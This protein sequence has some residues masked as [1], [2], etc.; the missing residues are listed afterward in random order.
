[1]Y[2]PRKLLISLAATC[3]M[4]GGLAAKTTTDKPSRGDSHFM[5]RAAQGDQAEIQMGRL[6][7]QHASSQQVKQFGQRMVQ[8]HSKANGQLMN[9]ASQQGVTLPDKVDRKDQKQYDHLAS[10]N[11][12][13]FDQAY[14]KYMIKDHKKDASEFKHEAEHAKNRE[15]QN[16]ASQTEPTL[17]EHLRL[18]KQTKNKLK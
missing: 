14:M 13:K 7:A 16:F 12:H 11:G 2:M 3:A 8:D 1:M 10:L 9:I 18:A 4:A 17:Q 5:E 15:V 6:A